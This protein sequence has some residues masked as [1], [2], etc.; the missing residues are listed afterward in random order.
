MEHRKAWGLGR[1][2]GGSLCAQV[3]RRQSEGP[4]GVGG[5][6][7][8]FLPY[9][10]L[11]VGLL[12]Y[13]GLARPDVTTLRDPTP[14]PEISPDSIAP[15][16]FSFQTPGAWSIDCPLGWHSQEGP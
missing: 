16:P 7:M 3:R 9:F 6:H 2:G 10:F 13:F 14:F 15:W 5:F 11:Q 8:R 4:Q 12:S 1:G